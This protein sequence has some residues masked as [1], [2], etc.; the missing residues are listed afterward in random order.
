MGLHSPVLV[1]I[2]RALV[3]LLLAVA[4]APARAQAQSYDQPFVPP[5]APAPAPAAP[6]L[7]RPPV[8]LKPVQPTYPPAA[9]AEKVSADVTL[10]IDID[11]EGH[12]TNV[13]VT[14][15]AGGG[16]DEA[17]TA[18]ATEMEF[19]PA[20]IDGKPGKIRIEYV[21]HF[22]PP[23]AAP[24]PPPA[25]PSPEPAA[26][27]PPTP[28]A[29]VLLRGR[30]QEKGT[31]EPIRGADVAVVWKAFADA[32]PDQPAEVV[33]TTD[34]EGRF[35]VRGTAP[36]GVRLIIGDS[37][38]EPCIRDLR[39]EQLSGNVVPQV[40][41]YQAL[42]TGGQYE[43]RLRVP[44]EGEEVTRHTLSKDE[45][46]TV[47]GTFG[48]PLRVILNLPGVAR[49][50]Y[51]LGQLIVRGA[52]P[53]DSGAFV[54]GQKVP[55]LYHFL[56]GPSVLTPNLLEKI[57]F[58]PGGFGVHYGRVTAGILDVTTRTEPSTQL[59]G[60]ADVNLLDS[61]AYVEGPL[62]HGV[63]GAVAAR[64]SYIDLLL[65][66]FVPSSSGSTTV[67]T[68]PIYWD[69]QARVDKE[70]GRFGR[71]SFFAFG[72]DDTLHVV[73]QDPARGDLDLGTRI[74]F[75]RLIATWTATAGSWVSRLSPSYGYD[76]VS[77]G[78]G[79]V[80]VQTGSHVFGLR[81]DLSRVVTPSLKLM[82]GLDFQTRLDD[83]RFHIPIPRRARTF[84]RTAPALGDV[85][86]DIA[87]IGT[88]AYFEALWDI[89]P[90]LRVVPGL[91]FDQFHYNK[92]D[93][94]SLDPRLVA[95]WAITP[96]LA[97]KGGVGVYHQ[98]HE[99]QILDSEFGNPNL[100]LI[101]ADQYHLGFERRF[102]DAITLDATAYF[103]RRHNLAV[104][105]PKLNFNNEGRG[106]GYGLEVLLRHE[107]TR[108]FFGWIS[109]TLSRSEQ[110]VETVGN[111]SD[112]SNGITSTTKAA[113]YPTPFDQLHNFIL[114]ASYRLRA[115][116]FGTR[117]RVVTGIPET[118]I[119]GAIYD[120]DYSTYR[121]VEG[122]TN[123]I[124]RQ[125]FHQ[126]DLRIEKTWTRDT[127]R[128]GVYLDV[129]NVYNAQNPE[130]TIYDY[131]YRASA[132]VRGLPLL[133]VLGVR[134]RF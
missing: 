38:H 59:H 14:K 112:G 13:Q 127:W 55:I 51:G 72:S 66:Y 31:R 98:P 76:I 121:P 61:S 64:R 62:G 88:A 129:Q 6:K 25:P 67:L 53:Q 114:V 17:A 45:M 58:Y 48:D 28:P 20:E 56:G 54:N 15:P 12:V 95:R 47:P 117:F 105:D 29:P 100:P 109:Y 132:P 11:A 108:N 24:Q 125:T 26:P 65:P 110:T 49:M 79:Q 18:A 122:P 116:E 60:A 50:P 22:R 74:G 77:F 104:R 90:R 103:L 81:E 115:W 87:N 126:L 75:H 40:S 133:P 35:E 123:S 41:C 93:R 99:P 19:S 43:T 92:T 78:A 131:R 2:S 91:R 94:Y 52:A 21:I 30:M 106:R 37:D 33:T 57:D 80:A 42:R 7:T 44:R 34:A 102:S 68:T 10:Q 27:P 113:Y 63:S 39:P 111:Q 71:L 128:L 32:T 84:G 1:P 70:L 124:R 4:V 119:N 82:A 107:I 85:N 120:S 134:G 5:A 36:A 101:W 86:R 97:F 69:Y 3:A 23:V 8:L 118:P 46:T 73:S 16:F 9:L 89:H 83:L 96:R 130:A